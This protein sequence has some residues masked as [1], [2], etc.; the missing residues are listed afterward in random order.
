VDAPSLLDPR[1]LAVTTSLAAL[2]FSTVLWAALRDGDPVPGARFWFYGAVL[3][4]VGLIANAMQNYIVDFIPRVVANVAMVVACFLIWQGSRLFNQRENSVSLVVVVAATIALFGNVFFTFF[5]PSVSGRVALTSI[6]LAS[7]CLLAAYEINRAR[8]AHLRLGV[9]VTCWPLLLFSVF[10]LIRAIDAMFGKAVSYTMTPSAMN[11]TT[12]L[13]ANLTLLAVM[14][15]LV[16][17][18]NSTRAAQVRALAYNDQLTG[19]YSRRGFYAKVPQLSKQNSRSWQ[20]FAFDIDQFKQVNDRGGHETG[21]K[22][23]R[24]L[25][26]S[27]AAHAPAET[28]IARFGGDEFVAITSDQLDPERFMQDVRQTFTDRSSLVLAT[29]TILG[30]EARRPRTASVSIGHANTSSLDEEQ[31][32]S[33]LREA[34]HSMYAVKIRQRNSQSQP[35]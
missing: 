31:L 1:T 14:A 17:L 26:S 35:A 18:V 7:G 13:L 15:G 11:T 27:I 5:S 4:S 23:L 34:D 2:V 21:D 10:L 25:T 12:Y 24:I 9:M 6:V 28:V 22:L 33:A 16:I 3:I 30:S 32:D 20:V 29:T 19:V 8:D